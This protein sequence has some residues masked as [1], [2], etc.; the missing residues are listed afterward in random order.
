SPR[1]MAINNYFSGNSVRNTIFP[2]PA[3]GLLN[4][5]VSGL[6]TAG[7]QMNANPINRFLRNNPAIKLDWLQEG[8][9]G[10]LAILLGGLGNGQL[11]FVLAHYQNGQLRIKKRS[12]VDQKRSNEFSFCRAVD[13][14]LYIAR[15]SEFIQYDPNSGE[16]KAY[17]FDLFGGK[18]YVIYQ[19]AQTT[20]DDFW[21]ATSYGLARIQSEPSGYSFTLVEGLRNNNCASILVDPT[22]HNILW[23]GTK[24]GGLHR[25]NTT[26]MEVSNIS[27]RDGLPNDVIYAV[28]NDAEGNLWLSSNKGIINFNPTTKAIRNFTAADGMQS[29]EFNTH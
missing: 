18:P 7:W 19:L 8:A 27:S 2:L 12:E 10:W 11:E 20:N 6:P 1:K 14:K 28:L 23:V 25:L 21:L 17:A 3:G 4:S 5:F 9:D 16:L 24:G 15:Y 29:D 26:T 22:D 13:N